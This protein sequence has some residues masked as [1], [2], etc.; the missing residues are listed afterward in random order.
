MTKERSWEF[1]VKWDGSENRR[2]LLSGRPKKAPNFRNENKYDIWTDRLMGMLPLIY[3]LIISWF[4]GEKKKE[5]SCLRFS[6]HFLIWFHTQ[7][8]TGGR[9]VSFKFHQKWNQVNW[10]FLTLSLMNF[11]KLSITIWCT[12]F[13]YKIPSILNSKSRKN[14]FFLSIYLFSDFLLWHNNAAPENAS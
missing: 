5:N 1:R 4:Y 12:V 11:N 9:V 6:Y 13:V 14:I 2:L 8:W 3:S 10:Q 7:N